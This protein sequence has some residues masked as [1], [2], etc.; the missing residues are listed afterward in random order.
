MTVI[1]SAATLTFRFGFCVPIWHRSGRTSTFIMFRV[2]FPVRPSTQVV[3]VEFTSMLCLTRICC[4]LKLEMEVVS[5]RTLCWKDA[6]WFQLLAMMCPCLRWWTWSFCDLLSVRFYNDP[7]RA[8]LRRV[9][10]VPATPSCKNWKWRFNCWRKRLGRLA[11][12][13]GN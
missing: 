10:C 8:R 4:D 6:H 12:C 2:T 13:R 7:I 5:R 9:I 3:V 1:P 11:S